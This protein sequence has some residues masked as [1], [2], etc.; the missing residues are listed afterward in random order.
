MTTPGDMAQL[1]RLLERGELLDRAG[2]AELRRLLRIPE[3][4][5]P[6]ANGLLP[7]AV[8]LA[9]VGNLEAASNVAGLVET[10]GGAL[11]VSIYS[12][13]VD[14]D[15]ARQLCGQL[16]RALYDFYTG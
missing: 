5:D 14:P 15:E 16:G 1:L 8:V 12:Q 10:A 11:I 9:K 3:S 7:D 13:D 2:Q 6:L 4:L